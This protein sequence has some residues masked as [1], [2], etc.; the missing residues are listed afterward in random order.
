MYAIESGCVYAARSRRAPSLRRRC[1][2]LPLRTHY[3]ATN[4]ALLF[5]YRCLVPLSSC[6]STLSLSPTQSRFINPS[7]AHN[8][9][10]TVLSFGRVAAITDWT[11]GRI[12][13]PSPMHDCSFSWSVL[14]RVYIHV[15]CSI[16]VRTSWAV[17]FRIIYP[18]SLSHHHCVR[19]ECR[20]S[21][22]S[23]RGI[24]NL[25]SALVGSHR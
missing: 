14:E 21:P 17:A 2:T 23:N 8:R 1:F 18:T 6:Y 12:L 13:R 3:L 19:W 5:R 10:C 4:L 22:I 7:V 11:V 15:C 9:D 24:P 25:A 20:F 16:I